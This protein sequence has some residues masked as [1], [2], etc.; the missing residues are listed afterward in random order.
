VVVSDVPPSIVFALT[1][2]C[3]TAGFLLHFEEGIHVIGLLN[4]KENQSVVLNHLPDV[5]YY[6]PDAMKLKDRKAFFMWYE[7]NYRQRFMIPMV[8]GRKNFVLKTKLQAEAIVMH[9]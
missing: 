5:H 8:S 9:F 2:L 3:P 1:P 7:T 4:R 6:N